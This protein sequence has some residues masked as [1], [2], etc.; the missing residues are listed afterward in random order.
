MVIYYSKVD[1]LQISEAFAAAPFALTRL[2]G[3]LA[4][5]L[6]DME[7]VRQAKFFCPRADAE[8]PDTQRRWCS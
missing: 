4:Q 6:T 2:V 5:A 1:F 3:W 7:L 8:K